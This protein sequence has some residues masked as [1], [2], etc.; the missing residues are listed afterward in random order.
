ML[1][2]P[3]CVVFQLEGFLIV[4]LVIFLT[5]FNRVDTQVL[6]IMVAT[7]RIG[8]WR[9]LAGNA[10]LV[11][12]GC[13]GGPQWSCRAQLHIIQR[14]L[15]GKPI[16]QKIGRFSLY[17]CGN[18]LDLPHLA[19]RA[20]SGQMGPNV[21]KAMLLGSAPYHRPKKLRTFSKKHIRF[22]TFFV[23]TRVLSAVFALLAILCSWHT[24]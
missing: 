7:G 5:Y 3:C 12:L 2:P 9:Q 11:S 1:S 15:Y 8:S 23:P 17:A 20:F 19:K 16:L 14:W 6:M 24:F 21:Q 18:G 22:L 4:L 10:W 13:S